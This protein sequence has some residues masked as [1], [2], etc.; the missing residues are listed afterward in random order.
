MMKHYFTFP[1]PLKNR[2]ISL[3]M[4]ILMFMA[5]SPAV[6]QL[7]VYSFT[8]TDDCP[9][10]N[11]MVTAQPANAIF[12]NFVNVNATCDP[13]ANAFQ[14]K[15][16]NSGTTIDLNEYH[17]F[18]VKAAPGFS[19]NLTSFSFKQYVN[20]LTGVGVTTWVLRSSRDNYTTNL[21]SGLATLLTQTPVVTFPADFSNIDAV[22]FRIYLINVNS[23]G[24]R[25]VVDDVT[26]NGIVNATSVA[27]PVAPPDPESNSPQC[28]DAGVIIRHSGANPAGVTWY[29][30]T[31]ETGT[32]ITHSANPYTV[33]SSGTY[34]LRAQD[35]TSL[36]WS[37]GTGKITV[38]VTPR[39]TIPVFEPGLP[40]RRC[41]ADETI[42]FAA[43]A[44]NSTGITYSL[45]AASV[46]AGNNIN[47]STGE[48]R[49]IASWNGTSTITATAGGCNGPTT[50]IHTIVSENTLGIPVFNNG[51]SSVRCQLNGN[52]IYTAS[53]TNSTNISY[54]LDAASLA[55]GNT[56]SAINGLVNFVAAWTGTSVI[57][58]TA[59]GCGG[60]TT[61]THTVV[62]TQSVGTPVFA[63]GA[64][65]SRCF[66]AG[67]VMYEATADGSTSVSYSLNG[68]SLSA[69]NT[70]NQSTGEV[71]F[72]AGWTGLSVITATAYGCN[73]P[74][75]SSH[76]VTTNAAVAAP[77]FSWG[78]TSTRC[79]GANTVNYTATALNSSS[80]SY[81]LDASSLA[82]GNTINSATG[83]VTYVANWTG[84]SVVT[85]SAAGCEGPV[86]SM[87]TV[88][89]NK[90]VEIPVFVMGAT[91]SR[92]I[93]GGTETY[94][95]SAANATAI[96]YT[97]NAAGTSGGNTINAST[98]EVTFA[99]NWSGSLVVTATA[100]GCNGPVIAMHTVTVNPVV[101]SPVF[102][103]GTSS[104]RCQGADTVRY[105][106]T[107][108][109]STAITYSLD[110][111]SISGGN[112]IN[113]TTGEI[114]FDAGWDGTTVVTASASGCNGP[115]S[116]THTINTTSTVG[117]PVFALGAA[118]T[119]CEG[120]NNIT[121]TATAT[122]ATD[123]SYTLD[124]SSVNA[125]NSININT[126]ELDFVNNWNGVS[127][128]TVTA[129]GCNGPSTATHTVTTIEN[130][131]TPV[132]VM[133]A[134]STRCQGAGSVT[135]TAAAVASTDIVYSLDAPCV[136]AGNSINPATGEVN[137]VNGWSGVAT[138]TATASGCNG[139]KSATHQVSVT[140]VV[141]APVFLYGLESV[142]T[143][144]SATVTY[145]ATSAGASSITYSL[146][147]ASLS[148][149][150]T[151]NTATGAVTWVAGWNGTSLINASASG[152]GV[153]QSPHIVTTNANIVQA[154]LYLASPGQTLSRVDP[155]AT[156]ITST[157]QT[158][159][160]SS[161]GTTNISFTQNQALCSNLTIK[162]QTISVLTYV[163]ITSG[164]MPTNPAITAQIK[165][166]T[167]NIITFNNPVY[168]ASTGLLTWTGVLG[169]DVTVPSGNMITL[170]ITTAQGGVSFKISYNSNTKPSRISLLPVSTFV[171]ISSFS[172]YDAPYPAG[173]QVTSS[174]SNTNVYARAVVT[175]PFGY[176]DITGLDISIIYP[177]TQG[178][179]VCV[180]S[181]T[182]SRTYQFAWTTPS[183][184][185]IYNLLAT[186]RQGFE[187]VITNSSTIPFDV[188]NMCP[189][190]TVTDSAT[191]ASAS[192]LIMDVLANDFDPNGNI[193]YGSLSIAMQPNNGTAYLSNGKLVYLPN[194]SYEGRDTIIYNICD[195]SSLCSNGMA[196]V[197]INPLFFDPCSE[198]T[199][200]HV[201][202][203]PFAEN[204]ARIALDSSTNQSFPSNNIRTIVSMKM[205]YPGM[206]I[207]WDHWEDGYEANALNPVQASTRV[208]GDG[209]P[210]NGIA[211][212]YASDIIPAGGSIVLDNTIP[213]NPRV[214]ANI[215]Y[216]GRDKISS[217]GQITVT[218]VVGEPS[219]MSMQ[220][221]KTNVSATLD[222]GTLFTI[223]AGQ[224]FPS[225][226]FRYTSL[227]IRAAQNNTTIQ[228]DKDNNGTLETT[229]TI[230]EGQEYLVNG[231][232]KSGATVT[233]N[234]PIGVELHFGGNDNYSS[235]DVPIFPASWY[236]HTYYSPV[237]TTGRSSTPRDS[238]V[239]MLYNN[240]NRDIII[241]YS[242]GIPSSGS[243]TLPAKMVVRFPLAMSQT[244]AYKF[245]NP[246]GES[247]TAIQICDSY[248]PVSGGNTGS[249]YDWSFNLIAQNR[250]TD[251]A[252]VAWAPGSLDGT[253][254]DNPVWVT[255][256]ANTTVY[257][258]YDGNINGTT[259]SLSPCG[260]RYDISYTVDA[261][262]HKRILDAGDKDQSGIA[263]FT[264]DGTKLAAVYGE[265][266]STA[267]I[268]DPSWDVGSTIQPFCKQKLIFANDDYARSLI[269]QPVTIPILLND[270]GF[271]AEI[272][273]STVSTTALLQ[274][275]NGTVTINA[276]GTVL[277]MPNA[278]FAGK[279]TFEYSVCSTPSPVVCDQATVY[280]D[281]S[282]CPAPSN[283]NILS[284][285]VYLDKNKDGLNNDGA[286]GVPGAKV[287]LYVDGNCNTTTDAGE[288]RDSVTVDASGTYQF[289][290]YPERY[291]EDDFKTAAGASSCASGSDGNAEWLSNWVDAGDPT[292][293]FCSA[294]GSVANNDAEITNDNGF[295]YA[296]RL[297]DNN[298]SV[299]RTVNLSGASYAFLTFSYRRK[300]A[301]LTS[302]KDIIVQASSN[303]STFGTVYTISGNGTTDANYVTIYNQDI[304]AY[305]SAATHI[306]FLTN[307]NVADADTVYIS[308][309]KVQFIRYPQCYITKLNPST[310]P[311]YHYTNSATQN[312][313]TA[314]SVTTCLSPFDFGIAKS[315]VT[316]SGTLYNDANGLTDNQ[317]NGT[318]I[319]T[320]SG[321]AVYAY[322]A[323]TSGKV[324]N[325]ATVNQTT[326]T[327][328]F[329]GADVMSNYAVMLSS[330][331]VGIGSV[332]PVATTSLNTNWINTGDAYG[333]N[334]MSGSGVKN[335]TANCY[336]AVSTSTNNITGVNF[337]IERLPN[338]DNK[339]ASY[340]SNVPGMQYA[341][342]AL[343]GSDPE[344]G[345][346][347]TG[348]TY[349]ITSVPNNAVLFYNGLLVSTGQVIPAFNPTLF[350]I[351][352]NNG[353]VIS[354]FTY[355]A[356]DAAG[357][358]DPTPATVQV[359]WVILLPV[360]LV[361]F[362]GKLNGTKVDL[363]WKT[364]SESNSSHFEVERSQD[365]TDFKLLTKVN[366]KGNSS[367]ESEYKTIDPLPLKGQN[368]YRLKMVDMDNTF[369]FSKTINIK[370]N[371]DATIETRVMPNPFTGK[372]DIYLTLPHSCMVS[373]SFMDL[374]GKVVYS[375][376]VKGLKGFNWFI[377]NDLEKLP[378]APYMLKL[379]TDENTFIEKLIK[380]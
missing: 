138:I 146:D 110:A 165:Y 332:C 291:V 229:A 174:N 226:D 171:D 166:G 75:S 168:N 59:T 15:D 6:A 321:A 95:A 154:P 46:S 97:L 285:V 251:F 349:K 225:R 353:V 224:D 246:T 147:A 230:N 3:I 283:E 277:Y 158:A 58:A 302:G 117:T 348:K 247:F 47:P 30:Q 341:I 284:G 190:V 118:S 196:I 223:P 85:A 250:L 96:V 35:N 65:S 358:F 205:P 33:T 144:G 202:Y 111:A 115:L 181:S 344:D 281:I 237:P 163:S 315:T 157:V 5:G 217:S 318:A 240:L 312:S 93:G 347:G 310:I 360:V 194:G 346:L 242:S 340:A 328:S 107:A 197:T 126:G 161:T 270:R 27:L 319:G 8:G 324:V 378:S 61:A 207:V 21:G 170:Q 308:D 79:Q 185:G 269:N 109:A 76:V 179:T 189:P 290:T 24:T 113:Q 331:S 108:A 359:N 100:S 90:S 98:G 352:P 369:S 32:D 306:R 77:V 208:W 228:I 88:T 259:G 241:N 92:C 50:A 10:P 159:T 29:W 132:F 131:G 182:C 329:A 11:P 365:G 69:G 119:R 103:F 232:V 372:L 203:L 169:A 22:T 374:N 316:I 41:A 377:V 253:R 244:A 371:S 64:T 297:K 212:G 287:Y 206:V 325:R 18:S 234:A 209:N 364:S 175:N 52:V 160:L 7:G 49:F 264:C 140:P 252:T 135:Y 105:S 23:N 322:L 361:D 12:S 268:G 124:A 257:V 335:G 129:N 267:V 145:T 81:S 89:I 155:V 356:M 101:A 173:N 333:L 31:S 314:T 298:V 255:P 216:D 86:E 45:D 55:A 36:L 271:L 278:G 187:S 294:S 379:V 54:S 67:S 227:F 345:T 357:M 366:A 164:T 256:T 178:T 272:D 296:L 211:P 68:G 368:Y 309:V 222:Y 128:I 338:S 184:T 130:V 350:K 280:V 289:V 102:A 370:V 74:K 261:L 192:P 91:S 94:A 114:I 375:K 265:D 13:I 40:A 44:V 4:G 327:Y 201:Y 313:F 362:E 262:N 136:S 84:T 20:N 351:D 137:F 71:T 238:A 51:T 183:A 304:T 354:T 28:E 215:Y 177:V 307:N 219:I 231:G 218:Q 134:T 143:Q 87:H 121:Y 266:A 210:Y 25:W 151:I 176:R 336:V 376:T 295:G 248:T 152:C 305:A 235:R 133:G 167:N 193:N 1:Q 125:G 16:W 73:G 373:F 274:P 122:N 80:I 104:V 39:V 162:A 19:L 37:I 275:K 249:D 116:S 195:N 188:C 243:I 63:L 214:T 123:I 99:A 320:V 142:R 56:I 367:V 2:Y 70:I 82:A 288:L 317:V 17:E 43:T 282:A 199:Q 34:Y 330:S 150:N 156:G 66:G 106:A 355:A 9:L 141:G 60:P 263:I 236:Y 53:A 254:N 311:A 14:N 233:A 245:V 200:S 276:N 48:V 172:I 342:P 363:F 57:T 339:S 326:G 153:S 139:P 186:A 301:T 191:G 299:T 293:G 120:S 78:A 303:G 42:R 279:D 127:V 72:V 148:A 337:G 62:S 334:N 260:M 286:T 258:K 83:A 239:V 220:C 149:G 180:D 300:S 198:A 343:G 204:D 380:Q 112:S 273:P 26:I 221:M 38:T 323:D 292:S 213:T